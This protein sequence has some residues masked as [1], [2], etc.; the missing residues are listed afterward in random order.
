M[1]MG[2]SRRS[3]PSCEQSK[4]AYRLARIGWVRAC[5]R[6]R[7]VE[8]RKRAGRDTLRLEPDVRCRLLLG[9]GDGSSKSRGAPPPAFAVGVS[10]A[11]R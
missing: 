3:D 8:G 11:E 9:G 1:M 10:G 6:P 5:V 4:F 7:R 2:I